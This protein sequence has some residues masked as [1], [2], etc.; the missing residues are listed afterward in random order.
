MIS[1]KVIFQ[2]IYLQDEITIECLEKHWKFSNF[3]VVIIQVS[4]K[5]MVKAM[6]KFVFVL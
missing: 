1:N 3:I 4:S 5:K 6:L 2:K